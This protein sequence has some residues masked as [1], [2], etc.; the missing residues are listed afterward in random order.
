[1]ASGLNEKPKSVCMHRTRPSNTPAGCLEIQAWAADGFSLHAGVSAGADDRKKVERLCRY[2]ARP[3][4]A[5]GR[6]SLTSQGQVRYTLKT[7]AGRGKAMTTDLRLSRCHGFRGDRL[8]RA[9]SALH[10]CR[11]NDG[12]H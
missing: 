10:K 2:I 8:R 12:I 11:V 9:G 3:P 7:P 6:L 1:M 5:T 4:A